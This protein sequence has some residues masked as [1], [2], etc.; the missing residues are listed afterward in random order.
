MK[1]VKVKNDA[2]A[3]YHLIEILDQKDFETSAKIATITKELEA[4]EN[5]Q[6]AVY[7]K[8]SEF[9]GKYNTAKAFDDATKKESY[10]KRVA[11]NIKVNDFSIPGIGNSRELIR[12]VYESKEGDVSQVFPLN[13]RYI[14]AKVTTVQKPGLM[15]LDENI[16][17]QIENI[18]RGE[19]KTKM[20]IDKYKSSTT[21]EAL[22][23]ASAQPINDADSFNWAN[24]YVNHI[25]YV[26][27]LVGY[28]FSK[29]AKI[30]TLC[31]PFQGQ[32]GVYYISIK[33]KFEK[34]AP[35]V[36]PEQM[37]AQQ[38]SMAMMLRNSLGLY[39][40]TLK[41]AAKITYSVKNL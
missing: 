15:K 11:E 24:S 30:N 9:A 27:K 2:Y 10:N 33:Y 20:I 40:E 8:A 12:W 1:V 23:T 29:N 39:T 17:P 36:T 37:Q 41:K 19:K 4:S 28:I 38:M 31:P 25:G 13:Q 35:Q 32:D 21:I 3:G 7:A 26:P 6:S 22:G 5:T 14:V 16:K 18:V 34:P